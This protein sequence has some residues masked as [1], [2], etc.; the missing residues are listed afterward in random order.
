[1]PGP[2]F[3]LLPEVVA[4]WWRLR[5]LLLPLLGWS[6]GSALSLRLGAAV[7]LLL[8]LLQLLLLQLRLELLLLGM[9]L[10]LAQLFGLLLLELLLLGLLLL[11]LVLLL[12]FLKLPCLDSLNLGL[13]GRGPPRSWLRSWLGI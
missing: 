11:L 7:L 12:L 8:L 1:M 6:R 4:Q 2:P 9:Q 3:A 13:R 10:L 5:L